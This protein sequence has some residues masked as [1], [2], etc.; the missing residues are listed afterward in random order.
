MQR[1]TPYLGIVAALLLG[2]FVVAF[3]NSTTVTRPSTTT[4]TAAS[5]TLTVIPGLTVPPVIQPATNISTTSSAPV[6][7]APKKIVPPAP[8]PVPATPL[9]PAVQPV[10][11][12]AVSTPAPLASSDNAGLDTAATALRAALVNI[13]CHAPVGGGL[14]SISGSG[15]IID[16]KGII[17][18]NAHVAQY[19]L[20][21][22]RGVSCTIRSGSPAADSYDAALI[23]ISPAW[24]RANPSVLTQA[25]PS[26]TG[27]YDFALLAITG[28]ATASSLPSAFPSLPLAQVPPQADAPVVIASYG[29][30]FLQT[31]E[32]QSDL[33]PTVVFGSVKEVYT[34]TTNTIDV[35]DLGGS[36]AAQE[37]S[38]GGGVA[39]A[40]GSLVGT[41]TT[42]TTEGATD[43]RSLDAITASYIRGEYAD[44]TGSALDILLAEPTVTAITDFA[45]QIPMLESI[46]STQLP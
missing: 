2:A 12:P 39:D 46:I 8:K 19:F 6:I 15:V 27:Q 33:F 34:F 45:P 44:E 14:H 23:Y 22:D 20:L 11:V 40:S 37:G 29:A 7:P 17:L 43:T 30:Q 24:L 32:I 35:L 42:S 21:A 38:S 18:T 10:S 28:S 9:T 13:I 25:S 41:I 31:N 5:T 16:S 1:A 3:F 4:S 26:G 36:A